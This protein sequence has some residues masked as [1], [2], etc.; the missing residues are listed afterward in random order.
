MSVCFMITIFTTEHDDT[1]AVNVS[2]LHRRIQKQTN[3]VAA[4]VKRQI[5]QTERAR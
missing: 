2:R 1:A 5:E 4:D 3:T